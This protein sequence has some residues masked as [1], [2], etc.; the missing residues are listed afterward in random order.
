VVL[1][2]FT[3]A[4]GKAETKVVLGGSGSGKSTILRM[5]LGLVKPDSGKIFVD[6]EEITGLGEDAL[7]PIRKRVGIV[8]QEGALFDSLS[9]QDNVTYRMREEASSTEEE[10]EAAARRLLGFVGLEHAI[11]KMPAELSGGMKRRVA[12]ARALAGEPG[13]MLYDEPTAG[14]D[15]ITN[16]TICELVILLRDLQ[17]VS[18]IIVTH[19]L[20]TAQILATEGA[21][22]GPDGEISFQSEKDGGHSV[23]ARLVMLKDGRIVYEGSA[24]E[25]KSIQDD[26]VQEFLT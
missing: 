15:P 16:R 6:D 21:L 5:V 25:L 23:N 3:M 22:K 10:M 2:D 1:E 13:I 24:E 20:K 14:L 8:F 19:D 4:V 26:Y 12:I 11:R 18:S 17:E 7:M 9:V